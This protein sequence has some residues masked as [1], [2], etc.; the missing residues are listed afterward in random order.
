MICNEVWCVAGRRSHGSRVQTE[1]MFC[2]V[3]SMDFQTSFMI[4]CCILIP[5]DLSQHFR[6][7]CRLG[8]KG[9]DDLM[10]SSPSFDLAPTVLGILNSMVATKHEGCTRCGI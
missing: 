4:N 6:Y 8:H 10:S 3:Q 5:Q 2:N 9:H 1:G 7:V